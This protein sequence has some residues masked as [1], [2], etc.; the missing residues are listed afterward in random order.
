[1]LKPSLRSAY[2]RRLALLSLSCF[3]WISS[4]AASPVLLAGSG[5]EKVHSTDITLM[6][7]DGKSV[8]SILPDYQGP[9]SSFAVIIPVSKDVS[10]EQ[11]STLK[12]EFVDRVALVSAPKFAEFWEMD[13]CDTEELEQDW[14]RDM[15]AKA[16]TGFL[17]VMQTEPSK[18]V[19]KEML[20][21]LK[22]K[23]K[24]G[25]YK[26]IVVGTSDEIKAW[27][28]KKTYVL[29]PGGEEN[30]NSYG[31]AGYNFVALDVDVNRVEL[32]GGDRA[33]LSPIRFFTSATISTLPTRFGLPSAAKEQELLIYT[34]VPEKRMQVTNYPTLPA[35][36]NLRVVTEYEEKP[37]SSFNLK[38]KVG[39]FYAALHDRFLQKHPG[40]F[41]LEYAFPADT[42]G[43]PCTTEPLLPHE[44]L[45]LGADVFEAD[46]P[47]AV[48]RPK[49]P[50]PTEEE[51]EKLKAILAEKQTPKEKKEAKEI[52]AADREELVARK[53]LLE[54]NQYILSRL[55][56][57]YAAAA[58][59]KDVELGP[60]APLEGGI[61]LPAGEFGE[62]DTSV[63][64]AAKNE[65][66][67][68]YNGVFPNKVV[69]K[70]EAPKPHRWGK[71][72][73]SYRGLRKIW[74]AEDLSRRNRSRVKLEGA[75]LSTVADLDLAGSAAKKEAESAVATTAATEEKK[76][77]GCGCTSTRSTPSSLG[78]VLGLAA[79]GLVQ[80]R[81]RRL[82]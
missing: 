1:M 51:E 80:L 43:Q 39:E 6:Q 52:W 74:V 69:V 53:G 16:N 37:G 21:D 20:L 33:Q 48:R 47:E 36:T 25:E 72:P 35:P 13:P 28:K 59:P 75:V 58:M 15:T 66:Q 32:V 67:S 12:R 60:A 76:D 27:L 45:S 57:R 18:K 62:S 46:L 70:C 17:G 8:V 78:A 4:A 44:L 50:E 26:E 49:A 54:R 14:Q 31:A 79:L 64:E 81:R 7:K 5:S 23:T 71:A 24:D 22:A 40:S 77:G 30:L 55:H 34:F 82:S 3:S 63:K 38:E 2:F 73:R 29:P 68:R 9:L 11:V 56:Y 10:A 65:F 19:A 41:L 61:A 42:C